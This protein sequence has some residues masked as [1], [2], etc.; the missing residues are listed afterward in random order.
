MFRRKRGRRRRRITR[1][2]RSRPVSPLAAEEQ[3]GW[4]KPSIPVLDRNSGSARFRLEKT[5][6]VGA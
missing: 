1:R 5:A 6:P 2:S 3:E 4:M